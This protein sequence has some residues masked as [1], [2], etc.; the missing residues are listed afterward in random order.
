LK[1]VEETMLWK[2]KNISPDDLAL[3][4]LVD[5]ADEA[6]EYIE[7]FYRSHALSPNF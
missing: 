6:V 3:Y 4:K 2:E 7:D 5:T 1:W